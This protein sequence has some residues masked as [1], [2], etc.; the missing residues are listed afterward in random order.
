MAFDFRNISAKYSG[1]KK[2]VSASVVND[3]DNVGEDG[4][5]P[6]AIGRYPANVHVPALESR[7]YLWTARAFGIGLYLS[8]VVNVAL[9]AALF[10]LA[11][12]KKVEPMLVTFS[13]KSEQVVHIEPFDKGTRG[14]D[15]MTEKMVGEY[16]KIREEILSDEKEMAER[17]SNYIYNRTKS[18][19]FNVFQDEASKR[20]NEFRTRRFTRYVDIVVVNRQGSGYIVEYET[21]DVDYTGREV[22]KLSWQATL[23]VD[24]I[25]RQVT[26]K[27]QYINPLGFTVTSYSTRTKRQ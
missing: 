16:V 7:R 25:E 14:F 11:P 9:A 22:Q 2:S 24:Y 6:D 27:E 17:Y 1:D 15:L 4:K 26:Y 10:M 20:Y 3:A 21:T 5:K 18:E 12:L 19:E 23:T 8:L 13:P